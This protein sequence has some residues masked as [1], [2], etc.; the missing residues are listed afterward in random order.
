MTN[1]RTRANPS[2]CLGIIPLT[3]SSTGIMTLDF[4][5]IELIPLDFSSVE[6]VT[7]VFSCSSLISDTMVAGGGDLLKEIAANEVFS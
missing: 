5:F 2:I 1:M 3:F 6:L 4:P 7:L